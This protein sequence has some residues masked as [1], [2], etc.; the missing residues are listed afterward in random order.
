MKA[1]PSAQSAIHGQLPLRW[2]VRLGWTA[3]TVFL[4]LAAAGLLS[5]V[6]P[7]VNSQSWQ[8]TQRSRPWSSVTSVGAPR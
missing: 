4:A 8:A 3:W 5:W 6:P 2:G 1:H 7:A